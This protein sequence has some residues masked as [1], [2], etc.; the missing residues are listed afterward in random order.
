MTYLTIVLNKIAF[1]KWILI[2]QSKDYTSK[3]FQRFNLQQITNIYVNI[4]HGQNKFK[5][6]WIKFRF[7]QPKFERRAGI[8]DSKTS[9]KLTLVSSRVEVAVW[10]Q[11]VGNLT[12]KAEKSA[13]KTA[14]NMGNE[15]DCNYILTNPKNPRKTKQELIILAL[16][17]RVEITQK[18][19]GF[20]SI[21]SNIGRK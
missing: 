15:R 6:K 12:G 14:G 16:E 21:S 20:S 5:L 4:L 19:L 1:T 10:W 11:L 13:A 2:F 18:Q 8:S 3:T 17:A 7:W 9:S